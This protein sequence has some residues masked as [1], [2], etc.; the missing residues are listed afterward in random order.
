M[1]STKS[2]YAMLLFSIAITGLTVASIAY[3]LIEQP[4]YLTKDRDGVPFYTADVIH[5]ETDEPIKMSDLIR[6]YKGE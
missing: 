2:Y 5:P 3:I 4:A 1:G 6:N